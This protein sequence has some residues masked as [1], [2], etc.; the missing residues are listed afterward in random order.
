VYRAVSL[1][2][3]FHKDYTVRVREINARLYVDQDATGDNSGVSWENAIRSLGE[4]CETLAYLPEGLPAE[5]WIAEGTYRPSETG[6]K[7]AY[8]PVRGNTGYYGGFGGTETEKDQR[9]PGTHTVTITGDL[10]GGEYSEHLFISDDRGYGLNGRNAALGEMTFTKAR[11]LT[12]PGDGISRNGAAISVLFAGTLTI[13]NAIFEDLQAEGVGGAVNVTTGY[14]NPDGSVSGGSIDITGCSFTNTQAY[15]GGAINLHPWNGG[16]VSITDCRFTDTQANSDGGG[17]VYINSYISDPVITVAI[18]NCDFENTRANKDGGAVYFHPYYF[19]SFITITG[20]DFENTAGNYGGAVY[21]SGGPVTIKDCHFTDIQA[22]S[23]GGAV[24]ATSSSGFTSGSVTITGCDFTDIQAEASGGAVYASGGSVTITGCGFTD[25]Q[26]EAN[27]GTIYAYGSDSITITGCDFEN[28]Q[29]GGGGAVHTLGSN[30]SITTIKDCNFTNTQAAAGGAVYATNSS[31]FTSGSITIT[32]CSFTDIQA[33]ANGGTIYAFGSNSV[34]ITGCDFENIQAGNVGGAVYA[35]SRFITISD[36]R[37]TDIQAESFGGAVHANIGYTGS[38]GSLTIKDCGFE[39]IQAG[40]G[41]GAVYAN[42]GY[43][44]D[45]GYITITECNFENTKSESNNNVVFAR[46]G[47]IHIAQGTAT[48]SQ[49]SF[50]DVK[51]LGNNTETIGGAVFFNT[52]TALTMTDC[53]INGAISSGYGGAVG[54]CGPSTCMLSGVSFN[55]CSAPWG[56][57]LYGNKYA[58]TDGVPAYTIGLGCSVNGTVITGANWSSFM[59]TAYV[60]L[61]NGAT[62]APGL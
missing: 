10:G 21:A 4:A 26:A 55:G 34:T 19:G 11:A 18:T 29:A 6:D 58:G 48:L 1:D 44:S 52:G 36:S 60:Y 56:S 14:T 15:Y 16:S 24:Y 54:G 32:G 50:T 3:L 57:L 35:S 59:S 2:R 9:V 17:A 53:S 51:A 31:G 43:G 22:G 23:Y 25:I 47:G 41:G 7:A 12:G 37:F 39:N 5:I 13:R 40:G 61:V 45:A 49:L 42:G 27:G 46:G 20:C 62:I 38:A 28:I 33:E 30:S 8:F